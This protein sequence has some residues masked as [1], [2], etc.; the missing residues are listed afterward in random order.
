MALDPREPFY[1]L[2][3]GLVSTAYWSSATFCLSVTLAWT[4][5]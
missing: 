1:H 5:R 3:I 4:P 2:P